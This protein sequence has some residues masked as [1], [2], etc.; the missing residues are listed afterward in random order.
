ME[1]LKFMNAHPNN[2]QELVA[3]EPYCLE[4]RQDGD[5]FLLKYNMIAS[6]FNFKMVREARGSIF[7]YNPETEEWIC[8]CHPFDKFFNYGEKYSAVHD[9]DWDGAAVQQKVDGSLIKIWYDRD[10]WH[11]STNGTIDAAKAECGD[12]NFNFVV[13]QAISKISHFWDSLI[14][15]RCYMFE[16]T[17]PWNHIVIRYGGI[18]LWYLGCRDMI[19]DKE[20]EQPLELAGLLHP[21]VFPHHSLSEC[22]EAAHEMGNDEEGYV[23]C[24]ANYN[25]IKIK[26]DEYL[27][28]HKI[29]GNGP[30]TVLRVVEMWQEDTL[31][32]FVA[33]YPEFKDF[34]E[35]ITNDIY[36]LTELC[37]IAYNAIS[38]QPDVIERRDFARYANTYMPPIRA[39]LYAK[40]DGKVESAIEFFLNMRSR[41]LASY[42]VVKMETTKIGVEEDEQS[43]R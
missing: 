17:S 30:I 34:V 14:P 21:V 41:T 19:N 42:I 35:S 39:Y 13:M 16:L 36:H 6:D 28:L 12:Y 4:V 25:R 31:D 2:W 24:D 37:A 29:R 20:I 18:G 26:G 7:R 8:V 43:N 10:K 38:H 32:D 33:Y 23:V 9:I 11:I 27:R 15:T 40:L 22:V 3:A 5:Y 1:L